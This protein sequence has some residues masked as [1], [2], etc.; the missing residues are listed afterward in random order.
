MGCDYYIYKS[1]RIEHINGSSIIEFPSI[2]GYYGDFDYDQPDS[3]YDSDSDIHSYKS[4]EFE[5]IYNL[6]RQLVLKPR[7]PLL[8]FDD[9][10]FVKDF[11]K[12][13]YFDIILEK[14]KASGKYLTHMQEIYKIF[15]C[16]KRVER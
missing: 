3:D 11:Y 14:I 13:K 4:G 8:I 2:R 5:K 1:L 9:G 16:E 10:L 15:K 6:Y 7:Q 12:D